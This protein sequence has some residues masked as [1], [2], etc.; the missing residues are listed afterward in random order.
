MSTKDE[1]N[2]GQPKSMTEDMLGVAPEDLGIT[3]PDEKQPDDKEAEPTKVDKEAEPSEKPEDKPDEKPETEP[4]E[5]AVTKAFKEAGLDRKFADPITA[6][7]SIPHQDR[8]I[9]QI[10]Q[11]RAEDRRRLAAL[12]AKKEEPAPIDP[13]EFA[14]NPQETLRKAG[15]L[16]RQEA[17]DLINTGLRQ[18]FDQRD[19][20]QFVTSTADLTKLKDEMQGILEESPSLAYLMD[21]GQLSRAEGLKLLYL[22]A[23]GKTAPAKTT[24]EPSPGAGKKTSANTSGGKSISGSKPRPLTPEDIQKMTPEEMEEVIGFGPP[25]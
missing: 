24:I 7:K 4:E 21:Q 13:D 14:N 9:T 23:R 11:E 10:E 15:Y 3:N 5:D 8:R 12:E 18:G 6:L 20:Y 16:T 1:H 17:L 19:A 25:T 2:L 22:A